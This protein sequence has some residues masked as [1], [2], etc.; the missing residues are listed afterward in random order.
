MAYEEPTLREQFGDE[1]ERYTR[2][3][4]RWLPRLSPYHP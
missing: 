3:V 2:A 1:Y 4:G